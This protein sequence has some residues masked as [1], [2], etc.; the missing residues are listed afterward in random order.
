MAQT[1]R[2]LET[3]AHIKLLQARLMADRALARGRLQTAAFGL[4][5]LAFVFLALAAFW[6]LA[7]EIGQIG[8]AALVGGTALAAAI[9]CLWLAGRRQEEPHAALLA[10]MEALIRQSLESDL[11]R[12]EPVLGRVGRGVAGRT[13]LAETLGLG[14][15]VI[16]A[17]SPKSRLLAEVLRLA[18]DR[19][20]KR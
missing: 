18:L 12:L 10:Q 5:A 15:S 9:V 16:G 4:V 2:K 8:A 11:A 14:L 13:P 19:L 6:A 20:G 3:L 1:I 7:E 17:L